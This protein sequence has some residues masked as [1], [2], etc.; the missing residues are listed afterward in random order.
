MSYTDPKIYFSDPLAFQKG[1]NS[2]FDRFSKMYE[3]EAVQRQKIEK[4]KQVAMAKAYNAADLGSL[5]NVDL[6]FNN[7]L[8]DELNEIIDTGQFANASASEKSKILQSL[9]TKKQNYEKIGKIASSDPET[10]DVRNSENLTKFKTAIMSGDESL[11]ISGRGNDMKIKFNDGEITM[12]EISSARI[13]DTSEYEAEF[14]KFEDDFEKF[15][16]KKMES[17]YEAGKSQE[18]IALE[19]K[20]NYFQKIKDRKG[21]F[22]SYLYSNVA[23]DEARKNGGSILYGDPKIMEQ[24]G[25]EE[26]GPFVDRQ[27]NIAAEDLFKRFTD[28][29]IDVSKFAMRKPVK[30]ETPYKPTAADKKMAANNEKLD[31]LM[32]QI[33]AVDWEELS[34]D[35]SSD[36]PYMRGIDFNSPQVVNKLSKLG[37]SVDAVYGDGSAKIKSN[38]SSKS[39][40][41]N[42]TALQNQDL[43]E[44]LKVLAGDGLSEEPQ[45]N[46]IGLPLF[47]P[48]KQ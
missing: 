13:L 27:F 2:S 31:K 16:T 33:D 20:K 10:W 26:A 46:D 18:E 25:P 39:T 21:E 5:E 1:F 29:Q 45:V 22:I 24:L 42:G 19:L 7:A 6:K 48:T 14:E 9:S 38:L 30:T 44:Q 40:V 3:A 11:S 4:E 15:A 23:S 28:R 47:L 34:I 37:Y 32:P 8:Q 36:G 35:R 12:G 17:A 43:R 41:I